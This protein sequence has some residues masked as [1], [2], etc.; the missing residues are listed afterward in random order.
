MNLIYAVL[1]S[2]SVAHGPGADSVAAARRIAAGVQ[3][4]AEEYRNGVRGRTIL[5]QAEVDEAQLFLA[6]AKRAAADL[7]PQLWALLVLGL[8]HEEQ[9]HRRGLEARLQGLLRHRGWSITQGHRVTA[10][11]RCERVDDESRGS[12]HQR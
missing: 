8:W 11:D 12:P 5:A 9:P 3:L 4:A 1:A 2:L 6:V 7:S 10:V